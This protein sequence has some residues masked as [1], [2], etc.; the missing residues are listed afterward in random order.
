VRLKGQATS[1]F[2]LASTLTRSEFSDP[3]E[4]SERG[5]SSE[6][7]RERYSNQ[8]K[9]VVSEYHGSGMGVKRAIAGNKI[10]TRQLER[11]I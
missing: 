8:V 3:N 1:E 11:K 10:K 9:S 4:P 5:K 7:E 2:Y 6:R